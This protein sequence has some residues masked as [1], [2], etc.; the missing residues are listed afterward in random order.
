MLPYTA[1][2]LIHT[3]TTDLAPEVNPTP[4]Q[5]PTIQRGWALDSTLAARY[6]RA[7]ATRLPK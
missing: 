3:I 5:A 7:R 2:D 1:V 6:R 4:D